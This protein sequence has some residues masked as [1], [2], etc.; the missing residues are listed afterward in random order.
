MMF[1]VLQAKIQDI[2]VT[3]AELE[4]VGSITVDRD[5][6]DEAGLRE[7]QKVL[8]SNKENGNRF[9]TYL[10]EGERGSGV[11]CLNGS[12]AHLG[13]VGDR[14]ILMVF[15]F[16]DSGEFETHKPTILFCDEKNK[17]KGRK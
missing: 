4:Y 9:E 17:I 3:Q 8:V 15:C 6:L 16:L 13:K 7:Y 1:E 14:L 12:T 5:L 2:R 10:Y 11:C